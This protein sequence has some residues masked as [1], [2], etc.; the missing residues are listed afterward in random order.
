MSFI[1]TPQSMHFPDALPLQSGHSIRDYTLAFE[2][3][4]TLNADKSNAIL[5]CHALNASHHVAGVYEGQPK[6]EGWWDNMI[7]PG[8]SVD[9]DKFFVIGVNNLG[10]CFGST[11]PMHTNPDTGAVYGSSFPVLTVEDWVNAQALLLDRLG[12][13]QMAAVLGGSLGGMQA[14]SWTLQYP[15]RMRHAVVVASAPNL[16]AENIA[17]NEVAR[18]AIVTDPDF[19]G[20][21]FYAHGVVPQRGLR[22]ARMIGHITYLSDDVMNQKFGRALRN[23]PDIQFTTQD[24]EFEIESYLRYQGDK[25]SGY[26]DANTYLLITRALDY[27]DPAKKHGANLKAALS[28]TLAKFFLVSFTTDW[29]FAPGRSREIVHALLQNQRDVGYAEIDAP[30]GHDAFLLDDSRYL[31]AMRAYFEGIAKEFRA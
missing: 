11:G 7:G 17:F 26:F 4:G 31:A 9:T 16:N 19:H 1:A 5:V 28:K 21:D 15:E 29:R 20:G 10:S 30:H 12:I 13:R 2:T 24:I 8:K 27:F 22:I 25:F 3:Y 14:L 18:R 6:S 23:G